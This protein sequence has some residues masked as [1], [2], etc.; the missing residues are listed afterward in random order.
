MPLH[1]GLGF[2]LD[3]YASTLIAR[4]VS[5][6]THTYATITYPPTSTP[7]PPY[8]HV[9]ELV[10]LTFRGEMSSSSVTNILTGMMKLGRAVPQWTAELQFAY[11]DLL[12]M[13]NVPVALETVEPDR[14]LRVNSNYDLAQRLHG[15]LY[16]DVPIGR[17]TL[18]AGLLTVQ[19]LGFVG[20]TTLEDALM[21]AAHKKMA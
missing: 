5:S 10:D 8:G 13:G 19:P 4:Y 15:Q 12:S 1:D 21:A 16:V 7:D 11:G 20:R 3:N 9:E 2:A 17:L 14:L 6:T 18:S